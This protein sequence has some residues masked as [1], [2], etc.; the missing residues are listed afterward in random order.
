MGAYKYIKQNF[1]QT[2]KERDDIY[3]QR[4]V[5]WRGE[6]V[7][8][9]VKPTNVTR[10]RELGYK[11]KQGYVV[12][13]TRIGK[14]NR[15][16][17]KP[18]GGRKPSKN[19]LIKSPDMSHQTIAEQ[20]VNREYPNLEVLNSYWVGEDGRNKFYEVILVDL[21]ILDLNLGKGRVYRGLSSSG[22]KGRG[23]RAKGKKKVRRRSKKKERMKK[24]ISK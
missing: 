14:G 9:R 23:L 22:Q 24:G 12:V 5:E 2:R 7:I 1:E 13:R 8:L 17:R 6:L 10:A 3:K 15:R 4:L 20:K 11:A 18:K 21:S 19:Y 16:R